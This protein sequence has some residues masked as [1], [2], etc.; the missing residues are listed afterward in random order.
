MI[1][2]GTN[3]RSPRQ[4]ARLL[5]GRHLRAGRPRRRAATCAGRSLGD[6]RPMRERIVLT[7]AGARWRDV[8]RVSYECPDVRRAA[9]LPKGHRPARRRVVVA[10]SRNYFGRYRLQGASP[11][12]RPSGRIRHHSS[13]KRG[14]LADKFK[15]MAGAEL[16]VPRACGVLTVSFWRR[17]CAIAIAVEGVVDLEARAGTASAQRPAV[18]GAAIVPECDEEALLQEEKRVDRFPDRN[19]R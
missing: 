18:V 2:H 13:R 7:A 19:T 5:I 10:T 4:S 12:G 15:Q 9:G 11:A 1:D 14:I 17:R 3:F 6:R 8:A 16:S